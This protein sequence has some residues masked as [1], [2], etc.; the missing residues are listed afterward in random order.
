MI[1]VLALMAVA[2]GTDAGSTGSAPPSSSSVATTA[3]STTVATTSTTVAP[4]STTAP[5]TTT[6]T[7]AASTTT[8][9]A[10]ELD[11]PVFVVGDGL[12]LGWWDGAWVGTDPDGVDVPPML[13]VELRRADGSA[14]FAIA[15]EPIAGCFPEDSFGL[16]YLDGIGPGLFLSAGLPDLD[17]PIQEIGPS[18]AHVAAVADVLAADGVEAEIEIN[19][20]LRFD[21]EG[22]GVDEVLIQANRITGDS[23]YGLGPGHY[24]ILLMRRVRG[25]TVD[26][27]VLH[28]DTEPPPEG[29]ADSLTVYEIIDLADVNGDGA[30][31]LAAGYYGYEWSGTVLYDLGAEPEI[32]L[33]AGCGV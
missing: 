19:R 30:L 17:R 1:V 25:G 33:G 27:I 13:G 8:T 5:T 6:S 12:V 10:P 14:T 3:A 23:V 28:A 15:E 21:V 31:E 18:P 22:D 20:V 29:Q 4:S 11:G 2:C 9:S 16:W 24:S 7:T 26:N 32:V